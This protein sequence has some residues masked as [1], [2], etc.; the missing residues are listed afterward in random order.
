MRF[1]DPHPM[2]MWRPERKRMVGTSLLVHFSVFFFILRMPWWLLATQTNQLNLPL[3]RPDYELVYA[4]PP[5]KA[6]IPLRSRSAA[7][8][9]EKSVKPAPGRGA[10]RAAGAGLKKPAPAPRF[11]LV[12]K[13]PHADNHE[14]TI[15]Q[16]GAPPDLRIR[17]NVPLPN[18]LLSGVATRS[19][20]KMPTTAAAPKAVRDPSSNIAAMNV[21]APVIP[22]MALA[23]QV[24]SD[25]RPLLASPEVALPMPAA[26]Q[27]LGSIYADARKGEGADQSRGLLVLGANPTPPGSAMRMPM[28]NR[29]GEFSV[30]LLGGASGVPSGPGGPAMGGGGKAS[31]GAATA[32]GK[33]AGSGNGAAAGE[34]GGGNGESALTASGPATSGASGGEGILPPWQIKDLVYPVAR[35]VK[36]PSINLIVTAP[37]VGGGGLK[38]YGVLNCSTIYTIY[39]SMPGKPWV[40]QYCQSRATAAAMPASTGGQVRF[41]HQLAPPWALAQFD[42]RR[43]PIAAYKQDRTIMLHGIIRKD[44]TVQ[45]LKVYQGVSAIADEAA[46]TA[47]GQW[48]FHP[49]TGPDGKPA[50]VEIL[51]GI[52]AEPR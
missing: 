50:A 20:P 19:D 6:E 15:I 29:Y 34:I 23:V 39:L 4:V 13:P 25:K 27:T 33:G 43:P 17:H 2:R 30:A 49:A 28:G 42:F 16:A 12:L 1:F 40:L 48:K 5:H 47:F 26:Q 22:E 3:I 24:P 44:G 36:L 31:S 14:Q 37:P 7:H 35:V 46:L 11:T 18:V 32:A 9:S 38:A 8:G 45:N 51:V 21:P 10:E 41:G 52:P